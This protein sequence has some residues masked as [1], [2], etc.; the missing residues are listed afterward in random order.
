MDWKDAAILIGGAVAAPFTGGASVPIAT[1]VVG[2]RNQR[3]AAEQAQSQQQAATTQANAAL[4]P[5]QALGGSAAQALQGLMGLAP[6]APVAM[7]PGLAP[8][9]E[10]RGRDSTG[11][12][13]TGRAQP[14]PDAGES[15]HRRANVQTA[16]SYN[17][18]SGLAPNGMGGVRMRAPN[19]QT[20]LVPRDQVARARAEGGQEI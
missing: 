14:R 18:H 13:I 1:G 8:S 7:A 6:S 17:P 10:P 3:Q 4:A 19:G 5:Y 16:S 2:A 15:I 12:E 9:P 20:Y 11:K